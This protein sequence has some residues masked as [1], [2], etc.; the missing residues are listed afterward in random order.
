MI[1]KI[2]NNTKSA[3]NKLTEQVEWRN[4]GTKEILTALCEAG[5][6]IDWGEDRQLWTYASRVDPCKTDGRIPACFHGG[7]WLFDALWYLADKKDE[8][9]RSIPLVA[10]CEWA[11]GGDV[12]DDFQKLLV[13]RADVRVMVWEVGRIGPQG[14][15]VLEE[16]RDWIRNYNAAKLD[17]YLLAEAR[18]INGKSWCFDF[19]QLP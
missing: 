3:L 19:H 10:E 18:S 11:Q 15:N 5:H 8:F 12:I 14:K 17:I 7:E 2:I 6:R 1:D 4:L 16:M 13:A 9:M